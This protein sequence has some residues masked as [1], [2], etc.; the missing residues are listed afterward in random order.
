[1]KYRELILPG[2]ADAQSAQAIKLF[3][4]SFGRNEIM[5]TRRD[6]AIEKT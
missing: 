1:M 5:L 2:T 6:D 4:A 3:N